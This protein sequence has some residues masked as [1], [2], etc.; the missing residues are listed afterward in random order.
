M[1]TK[2]NS[3]LVIVVVKSA[4]IYIFSSLFI[5][6]FTGDIFISSGVSIL[7][8]T[9]YFL[10]AH[11]KETARNLFHP[12]SYFLLVF[13]FLLFVIP[14]VMVAISPSSIS[15]HVLRFPDENLAI[16]SLLITASFSM[17]VVGY[18]LPLG[19][20][21][22]RIVPLLGFPKKLPRSQYLLT[23]LLLYG[24]GWSARITAWGAGLH[25]KN[26]NLGE[27]TT[28]VSSVLQ[29]LSVFATLSFLVLILIRFRTARDKHLVSP[30]N[31]FVV[32]L[33][34]LEVFAGLVDGS[35]T[36]MIIPLV[37][38]AFVYNYTYRRIKYRHVIVGVIVLVTIL[39]PLATIFRVSYY[40]TLD[41]SGASLGGAA[42]TLEE[43]YERNEGWKY[44][45]TV[46][47]VI[48]RL[49]SQL[50]SV[51]VVYDSVP[52]RVDYAEGSMLFPGALINVIPRLFWADKPIIIPGREFAQIFW[53]INMGEL[54]ATNIG[55]GW[56]GESYYN[57]G[58]FGLGIPLI[59]GAILKFFVT[60]LTAYSR[61]EVNWLPR[62]YFALFVVIDFGTLFYYPSGLLRS[63]ILY[64]MYLSILNFS[65]PQVLRFSLYQSDISKERFPVGLGNAS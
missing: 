57:F 36:L 59:L 25:H 13:G 49:S 2:S 30:F 19:K 44:R 51:L 40:E 28:M 5:F 35:R 10:F 1:N 15:S 55:L 60:R 21:I 24:V 62:L 53:G 54:F 33:I 58:W 27:S 17:F 7:I 38:V 32:V 45:N 4:G 22:A 14:A 47:S 46:D 52:R 61:I 42:R 43:I 63:A 26:P 31:A 8:A 39:A 23:A 64:L 6:L 9:L 29:P 11:N 16:V 20:R 56:I 65:F 50:E 37:Y 12:L 48:R 18:K 3:P 34:I 41:E